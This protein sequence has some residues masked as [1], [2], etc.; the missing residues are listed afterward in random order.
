MANSSPEALIQAEGLTL[1][2]GSRKVIDSVSVTLQKGE[3]LGLLGPNGCGKTTLLKGLCG[4][5]KPWGGS[6]CLGGADMQ[7]LSGKQIAQHVA[8]VPQSEEHIFDFT[9]R[10]LTLM[11][12][13]PHSNDLFESEEDHAIVQRAMS[14]ADCAAFADRPLAT[15]SGGE[16]QRALI[17]RAL[18][19]ETPTILCDEPTTHLD[20]QHQAAVGRLLR[21][22]GDDGH[23]LVLTTHDLNLALA[24]CDR[25]IL[26]KDGRIHYNGALV[27]ASPSPLED[28]FG[29]RFHWADGYVWTKREV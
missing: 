23:A 22:L 19:Q 28:V 5:L 16:A 6:V 20:P 13:L 14:L 8:Y 10:Q 2:Y 17:A 26:L 29:A 24:C 21:K 12:R 11:G 18:A 25:V 27:D 4:A 3:V 15:L 1:G 7:S 9:V